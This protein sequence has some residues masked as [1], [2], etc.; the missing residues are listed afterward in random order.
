M[1]T[2]N[3]RTVSVNGLFNNQQNIKGGSSISNYVKCIT[4]VVTLGIAT[5]FSKQ[6]Q[7]T[8][9]T[10]YNKSVVFVQKH[11]AIKISPLGV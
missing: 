1:K 9:I 10:K 3:N 2:V 4:L 11:N 8:L 6:I 7:N 5:L